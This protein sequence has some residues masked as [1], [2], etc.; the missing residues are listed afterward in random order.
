[1]LPH[2]CR[3]RTTPYHCGAWRAAG[4]D[5][6]HPV[7]PAFLNTPGSNCPGIA[8][9]TRASTRLISPYPAAFAVRDF[10]PGQNWAH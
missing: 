8:P 10:A 4:T 6:R 3:R 2:L 7:F 1:M 9:S 5:F